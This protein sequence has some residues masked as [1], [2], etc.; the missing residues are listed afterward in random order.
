[1]AT[2]NFNVILESGTDPLSRIVD[3]AHP[4][5]IALAQSSTD[6]RK[7]IV[8]TTPQTAASATVPTSVRFLG[9]AMRGIG[10]VPGLS[11][12]TGLG[13]KAV[14]G[15]EPVAICYQPE[16]VEVEG[17][18]LLEAGAAASGRV[19]FKKGAPATD[20]TNVAFNV[21]LTFLAGKFALAL[22][23]DIVF[24]RL[25]AASGLSLTNNVEAQNGSYRIC[26][27]YV[28]APYKKA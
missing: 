12:D 25:I 2:S 10:D 7:A 14:K 20:N 9:F 26:A 13:T 15:K 21:E 1:M 22:Q 17:E 18:D 16:I 24:Y 8:C 3:T 11:D 23:N 27:Q 4:R 19:I 6:L 5:G 28:K